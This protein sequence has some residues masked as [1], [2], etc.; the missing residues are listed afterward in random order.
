MSAA[1][2]PVTA[3]RNLGPA[4]AAEFA[5]AGLTSATA[6]REIG[7]DA[8]Y[9]R[10]LASGHKAHF[11][12][13]YALVLGLQGRPWN[14]ATPDEKA[15]LRTRFDA[16]KAQTPPADTALDRA[17]ADIGVLPRR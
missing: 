4:M 11:M 7:A 12:A 13:Y 3:I 16:L 17:L 6:I 14:D 1:D 15:A 9:A 2:D 5:R 10:L 8:A